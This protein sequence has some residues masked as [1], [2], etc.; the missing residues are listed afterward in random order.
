MCTPAGVREDEAVNAGYRRN[1]HHHVT[2][3]LADRH[4][5]NDGCVLQTVAN[6]AAGQHHVQGGFL[7]L[8]HIPTCSPEDKVQMPL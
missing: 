7:Q 2:V 8:Q 5:A 4:S 6:P 1:Q 3:G